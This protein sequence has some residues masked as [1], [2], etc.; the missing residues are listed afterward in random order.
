LDPQQGI[1]GSPAVEIDGM[2]SPGDARVREWA[3]PSTWH[4][5]SMIFPLMPESDLAALAGDIAQH[6]LLTPLTVTS[7]LLLDG[8]NRAL[9]CARVGIDPVTVEWAGDGS[10]V[11]WVLSQNLHRRH[12]STSQRALIA[13]SVATRRQGR[14]VEENPA[15]LPV[16]TQPEAAAVLNVSER[17]VR[18]ARTVLDH[19]VPELVAAV[20]ADQIAASVAATLANERPERQRDVVARAATLGWDVEQAL[21]QLRH[22]WLK[23]DIEATWRGM[24]AFEQRDLSP[25]KTIHVHFASEADVQAFA[26]LVGQPLTMRTRY[27][28]YPKAEIGSITDRAYVPGEHA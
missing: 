19:G 16:W 2:P 7:G 11:E 28:W 24:P 6:G 8:R 20:K 17:L 4:P 14:P 21:R 15:S 25:V 13:A 5:A 9:A 26:T 18:S 27:I 3:D 1:G 23:E 12:L 22:G 10:P